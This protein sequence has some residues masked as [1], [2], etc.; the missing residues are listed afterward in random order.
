MVKLAGCLLVAG[1]AFF[2]NAQSKTPTAAEALKQ[3]FDYVNQKILL[4]AEDFPEAKYEYK[5]KPE[6]RSF[7]EVIV[8]ITSG[9][10]YAAKAGRGEK[11]KWDEL[12]PANYKT[13]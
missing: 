3:S 4:M 10:V 7:R 6:M 8:H 5:L 9:N 2:A 11:V 13:K 12:P 1:A